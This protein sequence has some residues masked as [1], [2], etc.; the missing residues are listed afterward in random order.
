MGMSAS[1]ARLLSITARLTNNEF[2]AQT[3]TNSKL[4]LATESQDACQLYMDA[5]ASQN[6]EFMYYDNNGNEQ[7]VAMTP[8]FLSTYAPR[9]NQYSVLNSA[10][11]ILVS[12]TDAENF[13]KTDNLWDFLACYTNVQE[14]EASGYNAKYAAYTAQFNQYTADYAHYRDVL[15]PEYDQK[16][17]DYESGYA[18]YDAQMQVYNTVTWPN[19]LIQKAQYDAEYAQYLQDWEDYN[20]NS[21]ENYYNSPEYLQYQAELSQYQTDLQQYNIDMAAYDIEYQQYLNDLSASP[22][23]MYK[24]F[25][26]I[27]GTIYEPISCYYHTIN[28]NHPL[29]YVHV[30]AHLLA[31]DPATDSASN[32]VFTSSTG[33][34]FQVDPMDIEISDLHNDGTGA[35]LYPVAMAMR[36]PNLFCDG[37]DNYTPPY[38]ENGVIYRDEVKENIIQAAID[39][40]RRPTDA[41]IL[42][43][44]YVYDASTNSVTGIKTLFQKCQDLYYLF[45]YYYNPVSPS[46]PLNDYDQRYQFVVNFTDG[47]LKS[48]T[49]IVPPIPPS[50]PEEPY[51][52][53]VPTVG[54]PPTPPDPIEVP[55]K[56]E[57]PEKPS[58]PV[59]PTPPTE[60]TPEYIITVEDPEKSQ[61]YTNLW[62]KMNGSDTANLV[63]NKQIPINE[64]LG[65]TATVFVVEGAEKDEHKQNWEELDSNLA[66]NSEWLEFALEHGVITMEQARYY[67]PSENSGKVPELTSEAITWQSIIHKEAAD[68]KVVDDEVA[69]AKAEAKYKHDI[70]EIQDKDKK[71]DQDLKKLETEHSALLTEFDSIK[72]A[73]SKNEERSFKAFS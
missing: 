59:P 46:W 35:Q 4:R 33:Q 44:D 63:R 12:H 57:A 50:K 41:E 55:P 25:T 48:I 36:N 56:P 6:F 19:Y 7:N 66:S 73:I 39:E 70:K 40:G 3:L 34:S 62:F 1:Q 31:Y 8:I 71:Y 51:P 22:D 30:L 13:A 26:D 69:I 18:N 27:L 64:S 23:D 29:C 49:D 52:P 15:L 5:L 32:E 65:T 58:K 38:R 37:D 54:D 61:W 24:K 21:M 68:I 45:M 67:N 53:P 72:E 14:T 20:N 9:K 28:E 60:P 17:L 11:K 10:G 43:S 47:D 42:M 2:R 16:M